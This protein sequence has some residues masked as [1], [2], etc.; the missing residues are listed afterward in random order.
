MEL[1]NYGIMELWNYRTMELW[2]YGITSHVVFIHTFLISLVD[3]QRTTM[4]TDNNNRVQFIS[5]TQMTSLFQ[6]SEVYHR[7]R[8]RELFRIYYK[9]DKADDEWTKDLSEHVIN[10][11]RLHLS[12]DLK[13]KM[14]DLNRK[15][16]GKRIVF[17]F[18]ELGILLFLKNVIKYDLNLW[19][20]VLNTNYTQIILSF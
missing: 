9:P 16:I 19:F 5:R 15:Q 13:I 20:K 3:E 7:R 6:H 14:F 18:R 12:W 11:L 10:D 2:N 4:L 1:W 17:R 8:L